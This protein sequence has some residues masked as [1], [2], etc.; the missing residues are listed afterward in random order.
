MHGKSEANW[1]NAHDSEALAADAKR[2]IL[3]QEFIG[4]ACGH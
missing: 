1:M 4:W 3:V 2:F